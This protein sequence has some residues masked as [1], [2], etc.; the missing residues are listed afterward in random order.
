M[1]IPWLVWLATSAARL[2]V[3]RLQGWHAP[4]RGLHIG[5]MAIFFGG[6]ILLDLRLVGVLGRDIALDAL[7]RL[8]LPVIHTAFALA[9][10]SGVWLFLYDPIQTGAHTWFLPKMLLIAAAVANAALFSRPNRFG[11]RAIGAGALTRHARTAGLLS[12]VL[13]T[14]VIAC[15]VAN[16]EERP[17]VRGRGVVRPS[18]SSTIQ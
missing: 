6:I 13:W 10:L 16:Q 1:P 11:L 15:A 14:A 2:A 8:I 5:A 17:M 7:S 9:M 3:Y 4:L 18:I 12:L